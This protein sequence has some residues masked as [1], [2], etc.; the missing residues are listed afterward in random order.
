[1]LGYPS[2]FGIVLVSVIGGF[3]G[4]IALKTKN[5]IGTT[6]A[7]FIFNFLFAFMFTS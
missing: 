6:I 5:I 3:W 2:V 1:V 7:H 4:W